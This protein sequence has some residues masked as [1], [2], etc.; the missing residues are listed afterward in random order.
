MGEGEHD[1]ERLPQA[2]GPLVRVHLYDG[3]TLYAVVQTR[4]Q[5]RDGSWWYRLC[6]YLPSP[7]QTYGRYSDAPSP[8]VFTAPAR[9]C[10]PIDGQPY[11]IVPSARHGVPM[12]W[13]VEVGD[14]DVARVVHRSDC[15]S[16]RGA[17]LGATA[18]QA[19]A[20]LERGADPCDVCRPD[21]ALHG[22]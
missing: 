17:V 1:G 20:A 16:E 12:A 15:R 11:G 10:D 4:Q 19:R 6:I 7:V 13:A 3:Q 2:D 8:V 14:D 18:A 5:E 9:L 22:A 21:R